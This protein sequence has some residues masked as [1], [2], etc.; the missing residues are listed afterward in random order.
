MSQPDPND[1]HFRLTRALNKLV[2]QFVDH[3]DVM[4][5]DAGRPPGAKGSGPLVLRVF[6]KQRWQFA[7]PDQRLDFPTQVDDIPVVV[8]VEEDP[9]S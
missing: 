1:F 8:I 9:G 4:G 6:V 5:I 7:D 3:P 2:A